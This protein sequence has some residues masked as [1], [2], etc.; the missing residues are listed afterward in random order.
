MELQRNNYKLNR[1]PKFIQMTPQVQYLKRHTPY[2]D[3]IGVVA[4]LIW[5]GTFWTFYLCNY[6][7]LAD[8]M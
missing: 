6:D 3:Q 4:K 8:P 2:Y 5:Y 7:N 1:N